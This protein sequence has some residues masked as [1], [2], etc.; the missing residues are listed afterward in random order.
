MCTY[1][2][3]IYLFSAS[4]QQQQISVQDTSTIFAESADEISV[5]TN[6]GMGISVEKP[7]QHTLTTDDDVTDDSQRFTAESDPSVTEGNY[8]HWLIIYYLIHVS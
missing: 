8:H 3:L 1:E 5:A 7:E 6:S 4:T 2:L